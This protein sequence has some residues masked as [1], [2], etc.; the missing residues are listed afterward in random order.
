LSQSE[1]G[2]QV[3]V[4]IPTYGRE[5]VLLDTI[6][7][8]LRQEPMAK[9]ILVVDQTERHEEKTEKT[10]RSLHEKGAIRWI[11]LHCP[12]QPAALNVALM[13]ATQPIV[14]FVDDDIKIDQGFVNAHAQDYENEQI[15]A[16]AGQVLQPGQ[17]ELSGWTRSDKDGPFS[18]LTYPFNSSSR[19]FIR[20]GMS[21][22]LSVRRE[23]AL[24]IGGFDENFLPPV[25]Y[26]F[27]AEFCKRLC[28]LGG[29]IVFEPTA[30]IYHLRCGS[31]GTR[32]SGSHLTSASPVHGVGDYYFAIRQGWSK[33]SVIYILKRPFREIRTKF[34]LRHPWWMPVKVFGEIRALLLAFKLST[35]GPRYPKI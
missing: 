22:N 8:F 12:S 32:S 21:G 15:W 19:I 26:R 20:N 5:K 4:A 6:D 17:K 24:Q 33:E 9:E 29:K 10:L 14:L 11:R 16:V 23:R 35:R 1:K 25:S 13:E 30:R 2:I 3:S 31:G 27:D 7:Q 34:H 18:D 28:R